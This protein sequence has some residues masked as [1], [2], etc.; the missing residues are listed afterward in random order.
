MMSGREDGIVAFTYKG[1]IWE[2]WERRKVC[3]SPCM[4]NGK[5]VRSAAFVNIGGMHWEWENGQK[6]FV[7]V[8]GR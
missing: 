1:D 3:Y 2:D 4:G 8:H 7:D 6:C 5:E